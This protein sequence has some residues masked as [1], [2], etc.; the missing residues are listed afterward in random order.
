MHVTDPVLQPKLPCSVSNPEVWANDENE[1]H[2]RILGE[3]RSGQ[4]HVTEKNSEI[5]VLRNLT[6]AI[7]LVS[8]SNFTA[9]A[10]H[11]II[12]TKLNNKLL[13]PNNENCAF[14]LLLRERTNTT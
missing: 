6:V 9:L 5:S 10:I 12:G 13:K 11:H 1:Y 4:W 7:Y 3:Y 14:R 2:K 8:S